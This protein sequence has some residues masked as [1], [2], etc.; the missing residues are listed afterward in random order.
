MCDKMKNQMHC[1]RMISRV[2]NISLSL[3]CSKI[4]LF[5]F[6]DFKTLFHQCLYNLF[7]LNIRWIRILLLPVVVGG[8]LSGVQILHEMF[9]VFVSID[10]VL[11]SRL[12]S[13]IMICFWQTACQ[14]ENSAL[15]KN[16]GT[17]DVKIVL[18]CFFTLQW[19]HT[20]K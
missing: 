16:L 9:V 15:F 17:F 19:T 6:V 12:I 11:G 2:V 1:C 8:I 10:S 18:E 3:I 14:I 4:R 5:E 20:Q 7:R 13:C